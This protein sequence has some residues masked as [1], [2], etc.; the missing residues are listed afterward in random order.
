MIFS[1]LYSI[2]ITPQTLF[3]LVING[4][5]VF[6]Q[7]QLLLSESPMFKL[8]QLVLCIFI[9]STTLIIT[10]INFLAPIFILL[11]LGTIMFFILIIKARGIQSIIKQKKL[12][13]VLLY[14]IPTIFV[15]YSNNHTLYWV[16]LYSSIYGAT[17]AASEF[18]P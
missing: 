6:L 15:L 10:N 18:L 12:N 13:N 14:L 2:S 9:I 11:E 5:F 7:I 17:S 1:G 4:T 8:K 3:L 16:P